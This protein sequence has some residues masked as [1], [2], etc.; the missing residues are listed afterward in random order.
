MYFCLPVELSTRYPK[1]KKVKSAISLAISM[2]PI[3][4]MYTNTRIAIRALRKYWT[5]FLAMI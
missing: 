2:E 3:K 1:G 4:V 5:I